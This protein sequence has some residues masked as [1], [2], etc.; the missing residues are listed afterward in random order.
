MKLTLKEEIIKL[1]TLTKIKKKHK[2]IMHKS[3]KLPKKSPR[4]R[5]KEIMIR[6]F[7]DTSLDKLLDASLTDLMLKKLKTFAQMYVLM[8]KTYMKNPLNF[9]SVK[10]NSFLDKELSK[11]YF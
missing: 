6:I 2:K 9:Y 11:V 8:I 7:V 1:K 3:G 10:L 4:K 5:N